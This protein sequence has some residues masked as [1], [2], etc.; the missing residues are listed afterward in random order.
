M[1]RKCRPLVG[2]DVSMFSSCP[3]V[4]GGNWL[5]RSS[6]LRK[7][8]K[9]LDLH[10]NSPETRYLPFHQLR[11]LIKP[12]T[13]HPS[14][15]WLSTAEL[16]LPKIPSNRFQQEIFL[17][18]H[19]GRAHFAIDVSPPI[20][21]P[22]SRAS[23]G[24]PAPQNLTPPTNDAPFA[25][26]GEF[27]DVRSTAPL[28]PDGD[29]GV[30]AQGR[31]MLDWHARHQFCSVCGSASVSQDGGYMRQCSSSSCKALHFPRTDPVVIM[32]VHR[33]DCILLGRQARFLP[34][35]FSALAGFMEPGET[36]EEAVRR[37]V[38][39]EAGVRTGNVKY[40]SSQPWPFPSSLM[41]GC[42]AEVDYCR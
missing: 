27:L 19:E 1:I 15:A 37:E 24:M 16:N 5:N 28:L 6:I 2:R 12:N 42:M 4:F 31:A 35:V 30:I 40:H 41:I 10:R 22:S 26:T 23:M 36:I 21:S 13:N 34:G 7:D 20:T 25:S 17:G 29:A 8:S 39:E 32:V 38:Q 9:L 14:L 33:G 18:M 11:A 3:H